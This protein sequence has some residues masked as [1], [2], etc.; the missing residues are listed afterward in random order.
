MSSKVTPL[1]IILVS[2][3]SKGYRLLFRYPFQAEEHE[4]L[5]KR[6]QSDN[7]F[8]LHATEDDVYS[9]STS[10]SSRRQSCIV[11]G[12]LDNILANILSPSNH[13]MCDQ[14]FEVTVDDDKFVGHPLLVQD[15]NA[16]WRASTSST[17]EG[18]TINMF[19]VVFVLQAS[20]D[21]SLVHCYQDLSKRL[22]L[23]LKHEEKR[24][25]YLSHQALI[26]VRA[27]D[28]V[29][30]QPEDCKE[31]PFQLMLSRSK[32]TQDL[33]DVYEGLHSNGIARVYINNWIEVSFCL[34]HKVHNVSEFMTIKHNAI[35]KSLRAIRPYHAML[36][37]EDPNALRA[38]LPKDC[39]PALHRVIYLATP[40]KRLQQLSQDA[41]LA[42]SQ[43]FQ[44]VGHLVY[45]GKAT[46]IYPICGSNVYILDPSAPTSADTAL[47]GE[48][49]QRF[50]ESLLKVLADFSLPTPLS[51]YR[52]RLAEKER[53]EA[54]LV[55][56]IMWLLQ[57]RLLVQ[58]HTYIF[59]VANQVTNKNAPVE[60]PD[61][62][63][64]TPPSESSPGTRAR[65]TPLGSGSGQGSGQGENLSFDSDE[66]SV[67]TSFASYDSYP[68]EEG[69][70]HPRRRVLHMLTEHLT[71]EEKQSVLAVPH[72]NINEDL[73]LFARLCPYMRG[74]H[75][76]EEIMYYENVNRSQLHALLDKFKDVLVTCSHQDAASIQYKEFL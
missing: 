45:W 72:A 53:S 42:L 60:D 57:K 64:S 74:R 2:S 39:S 35:E 8:A 31:S 21:W 55:K 5:V 50:G 1:S 13:E 9:S 54:E 43:V 67:S 76:L 66:F 52:S 41:D 65:A 16:K 24:C 33:R 63:L 30:G 15:V 61:K 47:S 62:E 27:E 70:G 46:V 19:N 68:M 49:R 28:E 10:Q 69:R 12:D 36:L 3:G 56:I 23:A 73:K 51:E 34:P 4:E 6:D 29:A 40:M 17:R 7:P 26:M 44:L 25:G 32:L 38:S 59:L 22:A 11:S 48:F 14:R 18:S 71:A 58:I 37:L 75:H 20:A